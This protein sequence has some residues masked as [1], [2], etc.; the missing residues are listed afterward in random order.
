MEIHRHDQEMETAIPMTRTGAK[1][2]T[3]TMS[4]LQETGLERK[5]PLVGGESL[6]LMCE[7]VHQHVLQK[8]SLPKPNGFVRQEVVMQPLHPF[9]GSSRGA[10]YP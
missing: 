5:P 8:L 4:R 1:E 7:A 2:P 6:G 3:P 10:L 9:N